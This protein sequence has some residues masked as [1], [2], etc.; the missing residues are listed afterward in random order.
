MKHGHEPR[1]LCKLQPRLREIL[2]P[3]ISPTKQA[4]DWSPRIAKCQTSRRAAAN[5]AENHPAAA[6]RKRRPRE[7]RTR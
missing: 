3:S 2:L 5:L 1:A 4:T 7:G 6:Q